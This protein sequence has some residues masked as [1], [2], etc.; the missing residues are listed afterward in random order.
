MTTVVT[1]LTC[2]A[3]ATFVI[4]KRHRYFLLLQTSDDARNATVLQNAIRRR[5]ARR[6][7][8]KRRK[9]DCSPPGLVWVPTPV[10]AI[11]VLAS[12]LVPGDVLLDMG[13]GDGRVLVEL[14]NR[15]PLD[16]QLIGIE[17]RSDV[18]QKARERLMREILEKTSRE[19]VKLLEGDIFSTLAER[20]L[21]ERVTVCFLYLLPAIQAKLSPMLRECLR[22]GTRVITYTF[23][24]PTEDGMGWV[25][26]RVLAT[27]DDERHPLAQHTLLREYLA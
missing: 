5:R 25:P 14:A 15:L 27:T 18:M 22:P 9:E 26:R 20:A 23:P 6:E 13:C 7:L 2:C 24:L 1:F 3:L 12:V 11:E 8:D 10:K 16:V 17:L 21:G 19:R 4:V